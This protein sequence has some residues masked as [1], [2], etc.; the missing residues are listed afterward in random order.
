[1]QT[2]S[3]GSPSISETAQMLS[4][5][6]GRAARCPAATGR[7]RLFSRR[8]HRDRPISRSSP[9][10]FPGRPEPLVSS[11]LGK[12]DVVTPHSAPMFV[13]VARSGTERV[14][15]PSPPYSKTQSTFPFVV[16]ICRTPRMTSLAETQ[17]EAAGQVD[18]DHPGA[19]QEKGIPPIARATSRPPA[20]IAI[21]PRPPPVAVWLSAPRRVFPG[22]PNRSRWT[23]WQ[24]PFPARER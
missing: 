16:K 12:T 14:R 2:W 15:T 23:W 3:T 18:P 5:L 22:F 1:M 7:S 8:A 24:M 10:P 11:S 19:V 21:I 9:L 17:A 13:I 6:C 4:G 20:P